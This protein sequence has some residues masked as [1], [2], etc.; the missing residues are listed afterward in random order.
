MR[1]ILR[2]RDI[3]LHTSTETIEGYHEISDTKDGTGTEIL[4]KTN[5]FKFLDRAAIR[6]TDSSYTGPWSIC[7]VTQVEEAKIVV[8]MLPIIGST[9][10]LN[11]C[12][13]QLQ[14]FTV[15]QANTLDRYVIGIHV[16]SSF[17]P[18]IPLI[19]MCIV[20]PLYDRICVPA[21]RKLTGIPT[22]IRQLQRIGVGLVL[23]SIS[24]VVA[25][26]VETRRKRIAVHH[27][28]VDSPNPLPMNVLWLGLQYGQD[29]S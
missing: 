29:A 21:L 28:M 3:F 17:I 16:P 23:A 15:Q 14:T 7:T 18:V 20:V 19:F 5:Q 4:K 2:R 13:A 24:M 1:K 8:R 10:F 12:L 26:Y 27:N 25:G 9:I 11:T 22:G 6:T